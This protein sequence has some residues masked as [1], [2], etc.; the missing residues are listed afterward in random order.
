MPICG[1]VSNYNDE[2]ITKSESPFDI[3]K[4][5]NEV[6]E[7]RFFVVFEWVDRYEQATEQ[8]GQWIKEGKL[9]HKECIGEGLENAP[10]SFRGMLKGK[11]F[12]KQLIKIADEE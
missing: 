8:L 12:G 5:L 3:L 10:D 1:Y 7:H 11:N 4:Q 2:D 9:K 6:P